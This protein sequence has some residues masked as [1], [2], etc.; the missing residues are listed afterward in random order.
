MKWC[1]GIILSIVQCLLVQEFTGAY[2][3]LRTTTDMGQQSQ[4][5]SAPRISLTLPERL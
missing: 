5:A 3:S 4:F 1:L 2:R